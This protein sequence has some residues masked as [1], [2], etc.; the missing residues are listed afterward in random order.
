MD[1]S[2]STPA[3]PNDPLKILV[4]WAPGDQGEDALTAAAWLGRTTNIQLQCITTLLRPWAA[5]KVSKI[6]KKYKKWFKKEAQACAAA[7]K[8]ALQEHGIPPEAWHEEVSLFA[9][10][11]NGAQLIS[12]AAQTFGA[13]MILLGSHDSAYKGR[14]FANSTAD[15]L[16][17]SSTC[18]VA[19]TPR[20]PKLSKKG[21]T[22]VNFAMLEPELNPATVQ[23]AAHIAAQWNAPL[24]LVALSPTGFGEPPFSDSLQLPE[25]LA[26][27]W[28]ENTFAHLD[29]CRD[30]IQTHLPQVQVE[31]EIGFGSGWDGAL[32][33]IKWKKGDLLCLGSSPIGALERVFIGSQT[34]EILPHVRVP[35]F[36]IPAKISSTT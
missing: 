14:L 10:G 34:S 23:Q 30:Q 12:E 15:A 13:D 5:P 36:M 19:L 7:L 31:T 26:L 2:S 11:T 27:E 17:H 29:R 28:R 20:N 6:G 21:V 25:N 32:D 24:R 3:F 18:P 22:R 8:E 33:A 35:V 1:S 9:D 4:H 16:L